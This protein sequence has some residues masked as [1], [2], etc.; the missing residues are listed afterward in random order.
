MMIG[1]M[2]PWPKIDLP[3]RPPF[4]PMEAKLVA[5]PP[6]GA[7]WRYEPKWDGFRVLAFRDG[8]GVVLQSKRG[9]PLGRYF[10]EL[11]AAV[12]ALDA[13]RF[14]IDGEIV[15]PTAK[16]L[17]FDDLLLRIHPA[18]SRVRKLA[19]EIPAAVI[20][21]D[22]LVLDGKSL[23]AAPLDERRAALEAFAARQGFVGAEEV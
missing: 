19:Q 13:D 21:F 1:P 8:E 18:E 10:P 16:G 9:L 22:A 11:E 15:I 23:I 2:P 17:S 12:R 7:Q 4:A 14:V 3:V 5:K 20:V 6:A